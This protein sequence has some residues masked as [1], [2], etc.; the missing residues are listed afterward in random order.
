MAI[1]QAKGKLPALSRKANAKKEKKM[2][3]P[4]TATTTQP[5]LRFNFD[6][7]KQSG[8]SDEDILEFLQSRDTNIDWGELEDKIARLPKS[9]R[10]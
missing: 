8:A 7:A 4:R 1:A 10:L 5:Q 3:D 6:K 9:T 2:V